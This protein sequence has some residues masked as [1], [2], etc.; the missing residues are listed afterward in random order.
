[1]K[2]WTRPSIAGLFLLLLILSSAWMT[3]GAIVPDRMIIF[4]GLEQTIENSTQ[5]FAQAATQDNLLILKAAIFDPIRDGEPDL[6][7]YVADYLKGMPLAT[8]YYI[9]QFNGPMTPARQQNL[10]KTGVEVLAYVPNNAF[11]VRA[12]EHAYASLKTFAG[13]RW[14][15]HFQAAYRVAPTLASQ[16]KAGFPELEKN[17]CRLGI[18]FFK[19]EEPDVFAD[20]VASRYST[21]PAFEYYTV[22]TTEAMVTLSRENLA[23]FVTF[24]ANENGIRWVDFKPRPALFNDYSIRVLQGGGTT[25]ADT[26][27]FNRG[28]MGQGQVVS[29]LDTGL[30]ADMCFY[31]KNAGGTVVPRQNVEPPTALTFDPNERKVGAYN[32]LPH[33]YQHEGDEFA[34]F[35]HGTATSGCVGG[36]NFATLPNPTANPPVSGHDQGDGNAPLSKLVFLDVGGINPDDMSG[37]IYADYFSNYDLMDQAYGTG[38]RLASVSLGSGYSSSTAGANPYSTD[39]GWIDLFVWDHENFTTFYAA[40]NAETG[41]AYSRSMGIEATAKNILSVGATDNG[42]AGANN[43]TNFSS[44]GPTTD[45]RIKPDIV[46]PGNNVRTASGNASLTSFNCGSTLQT[47]T[48]FSA[49]TAAGLA[50]LGREYFTEGWYPTGVK[51]PANAIEPSAALLKAFLINTSTSLPGDYTGNSWMNFTTKTKEDAPAFG[52]GWGRPVLENSMYF[53]GDARKLLVQ[54]VPNSQGLCTGTSREYPFTVNAAKAAEPLKITL[55]WTDPPGASFAAV[56]LVNNLD[57]EVQAPDG[58][59]YKGNQWNGQTTGGLKESGA[60]PAG[61]DVLNNVEGVLVKTPAAGN[62]VARIRGVNVPG[63]GKKFTQGFGLVITGNVA[64]RAS[65]NLAFKSVAVDDSLGNNNGIIDRGETLNLTITLLNLGTVQA[66]TVV[67]SLSCS[68]AGVT[69]TPGT[70]SWGNIPGLSSKASTQPFQVAIGASVPVSTG[71]DFTLH[72]TGTG[73]LVFDFPFH[74]QTKPGIPPTLTNLVLTEGRL[75]NASYKNFLYFYYDFDYADPDID[76]QTL[77]FYFRVNGQDVN[78]PGMHHTWTPELNKPS[79]SFE[80]GGAA[81]FIELATKK[82]ATYQIYGYLEDSNGNLSAIAESNEITLTKGSTATTITELDD[83]DNVYIPFA[84]GFTFPFYGKTYSGCWVN[85]DGN[86]SF[87]AGYDWMDR[88]AAVFLQNMPRISLFLTDVGKSPGDT[89]I[90]LLENSAAHFTIK[91]DNVGQWTETGIVGSNTGTITLFPDGRVDFAYGPCTMSESDPYGDDWGLKWKAIC[92]LCPGGVEFQPGM[93]GSDLSGFAGGNITIPLGGPVWQGFS[94]TDNFD[95]ASATLHFTPQAFGAAQTLY[96]PR[97]SLVPGS[98]YEG[99]GFANPND[100]PARVRYTGY[101]PAG[102]SIGTSEFVTYPP[103]GQGAY[104]IDQLL[105]LSTATDA[106]VAAECDQSGLKGFFLTQYLNG[107]LAGLDGASVFSSTI[108]SGVFPRV[109][110]SN[111]F[112]TQLFIANPGNSAV[113]VTL[114]GYD[115]AAVHNAPVINIPAMGVQKVDV[116]TY[117]GA[118]FDG[119]LTLQATGGVV[120]NSLIFD[121]ARSIASINLIPA[122]SAATKLYAAHITRMPDIFYSEANIINMGAAPATVTVSPYLADGSA[123]TPPFQVTIPANQVVTLRDDQLGLPSGQTTDGWLKVESANPLLGCLTFGNPVDNK[124]QST[125]PL[126]SAGNTDLYFSQVAKGLSGGIDFFTG[127]S[128]VNPN[129]VPANIL[130]EVYYKDGTFYGSIPW[131]L[132]P[133]E[134]FVRLLQYADYIGS[135]LPDQ[136]SGYLR[137]TSDQPVLA[138]ELFGNNATIDFLCAVPA[139]P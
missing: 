109:E 70:K 110:T 20:E 29:V 94:D 33:P 28:L 138:F 15:G 87:Q 93:K 123:L 51:T 55:V 139:Q 40:G 125:L 101:N 128:V 77:H 73:G 83:D 98:W 78:G 86:I 25:A 13:V 53:P 130:V 14:L 38:A 118:A 56:A 66:S 44:K 89:K 127:F 3:A 106:W 62:W 54:D 81:T 9:V 60:N 27:I 19:G 135:Y 115:G 113:A 75:Y 8:K 63:Y 100:G 59:I 65:A 57:L 17:R 92:G 49:P 76:I 16:M 111:A 36:D 47:G 133:G 64:S 119:Y 85:S 30:D 108:T 88:A 12:G 4:P 117:F 45:G 122:A 67:G 6:G 97:L 11:L 137:I 61:T 69:V 107:G 41:N 91:W 31:L 22:T 52:Q 103:H 104:Q 43:V 95:L 42:S 32:V 26:T 48:S 23:D 5:F 102:A 21:D 1:M 71:L 116:E 74:L 124:N 80:G 7:S 72:V 134:K 82:G 131:T 105:H 129:T 90:Q 136:D 34:N 50:A 68:N 99:Y 114:T 132:L 58:T 35:F 2:L 96:F 37:Y 79:G 46:A 10:E 126:Q 39:T 84:A 121:G 24:A 112:L 120:G 18:S